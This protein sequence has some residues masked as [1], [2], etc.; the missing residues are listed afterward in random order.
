MTS[1]KARGKIMAVKRN[2]LG[3]CLRS[4][5]KISRYREVRKIG[6]YIIGL[7]NFMVVGF[8]AN[9]FIR[10]APFMGRIVFTTTALYSS[11]KICQS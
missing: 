3:I 5:S 7:N 8:S 4:N 11:S 9:G 10:T 1:Y 6:A 2:G